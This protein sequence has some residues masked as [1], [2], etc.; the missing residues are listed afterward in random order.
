MKYMWSK[1]RIAK[2]IVPILNKYNDRTYYIEPFVWWANRIT[3]SNNTRSNIFYTYR[4]ETLSL[5]Q[6]CDKLWLKYKTVFSRIKY[7][8]KT[9]EE[10]IL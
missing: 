4:S 10:A 2:Y 3:Q 8:W 9:F 6:W 1:N 5:K 7:R